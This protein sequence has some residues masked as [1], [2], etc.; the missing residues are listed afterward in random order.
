VDIPVEN[1]SS[2]LKQEMADGR[3]IVER[4]GKMLASDDALNDADAGM[5]R[6]YLTDLYWAERRVARKL[7]ALITSAKSFEEIDPDKA[8][9]WW[10]GNTGFRLAPAQERAVRASLENKVSI[11]TGGPGVGKTTIIRALVDIYSARRNAKGQP[12]ISVQTAAPTG[13][14]AKRLSESTGVISQTVHRLLKYNPQTRRFTY[15]ADNPLVGD[16][17]VFDETSM[18]DI[19]LMDSLLAALPQTAVLIIVG[20]TDQLPS[21]GPG[22]VLH[23]LIASGVVAC[24]R[25]T[26]IFRQDNS[27]L[28]VK[29]AHHVN[30]GEGLELP[31]T[32]DNSDFYFIANND[33]EKTLSFVLDFMTTRIP[34]KFRMDPMTD[35]QVLSPMRRNVLGT[36]NLNML[37]QKQLNPDGPFVQRGAVIFRK[38]DRVMQLRN[39]YDK[40]VFNGDVGFIADAYPEERKLVVLFDGKPVEYASGDLDELTLSYATTIHKSQGS[41]YSAVIVI[42]HNQHYMMLQRNL[43]YTAITRGK[44]LVLVIGSRW[45]VGKAIETN[46]VKGRRTSLA[47]RLIVGMEEK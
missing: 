19:R 35:V 4:E 2:A 42:L 37:L 15:D 14:A 44:K 18:L 24:S 27:G 6:V 16:V 26:E 38:G 20:D 32:G 33:P 25:L 5:R 17:F 39:N 28:I 12:L 11:I 8:I 29:N 9:A 40:D 31:T 43:L 10:E 21:V 34:R 23:D 3:V 1:L 45:A 36:E 41:E 30:A 46:T 47:E 13:R 7:R 22:N